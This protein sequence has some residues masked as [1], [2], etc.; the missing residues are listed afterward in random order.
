L[1]N[2]QEFTMADFDRFFNLTPHAISLLRYFG[3]PEDPGW[4]IIEVEPSGTVVRV[5]EFQ[6]AP[7]RGAL[8]AVNGVE[9][10]CAP[11]DAGVHGLPE[12]VPGVAY[13][14]SYRVARAV[15]RA[16]VFAPDTGPESAVRGDDGQIHYVRRLIASGGR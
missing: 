8:P 6:A 11:V 3:R 9:C 4:E 1:I 16:D 5:A 14:V 10:V 2:Q 13:L 7:N 12:P 15:D